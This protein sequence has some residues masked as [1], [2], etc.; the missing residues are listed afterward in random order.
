MWSIQSSAISCVSSPT[1][2]TWNPTAGRTFC[3]SPRPIY[4]GRRRAKVHQ[5]ERTLGRHSRPPKLPAGCQRGSR[6]TCLRLSSHVSRD[7]ELDKSISANDGASSNTP[8]ALRGQRHLPRLAVHSKCVEYL[9]SPPVTQTRCFRLDAHPSRGRRDSK[10][11]PKCRLVTGLR[12]QGNCHSRSFSLS[13]SDWHG[14]S[15]LGRRP[16]ASH[17]WPGSFHRVWGSP[18]SPRRPPKLVWYSATSPRLRPRPLW[19]FPIGLLK[20]GITLPSKPPQIWSSSRESPG[21]GPITRKIALTSSSPG[22]REESSSST[23]GPRSFLPSKLYGR[24]HQIWTLPR[25]MQRCPPPRQR[26]SYLHSGP[27]IVTVHDCPA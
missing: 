22:G 25:R 20:P 9:G 16:N 27:R 1:V 11:N 21:T 19:S 13:L 2:F 6:A 26:T 4:L 5:S 8:Q 10:T 15:R 12:S 14:P 3:P 24:C 18:S 23:P 17:G 7:K